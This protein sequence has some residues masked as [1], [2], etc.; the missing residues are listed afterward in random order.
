MNNSTFSRR[1]VAQSKLSMF[2]K[3]GILKSGVIDV[4]MNVS[5]TPDPFVKQPETWKY[6]DA[7]G[8]EIDLLFK[9]VTRQ[10]RGLVEDVP[11]LDPFASRRIEMIRAKYKYS[12]PDRHVFLVLEMAAIRLGP[13]FYK[14]VY[15]EDETK[16]ERICFSTQFWSILKSN[17]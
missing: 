11:W 10:S 12:S 16:N 14:V 5:T 17:N 2:S 6:S 15:Y 8:D 3:R 13:T 4:Q 9:Q 7:W 1:L